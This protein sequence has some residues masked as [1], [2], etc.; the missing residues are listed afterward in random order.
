[1]IAYKPDENSKAFGNFFKTLHRIYRFWACNEVREFLQKFT[2]RKVF[3]TNCSNF[4]DGHIWTLD[5]WELPETAWFLDIPRFSSVYF[6]NSTFFRF[7]HQ[8]ANLDS[9]IP[10]TDC[11]FL[12]ISESDLY[13][14]IGMLIGQKWQ[15]WLK[16]RHISKF[17]L[18]LLQNYSFEFLYQVLNWRF[19]TTTWLLQWSISG[20]FPHIDLNSSIKISI[21]NLFLSKVV[22][23]QNQLLYVHF[24]I[25]LIPWRK[26][27]QPDCASCSNKSVFRK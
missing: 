2:R 3:P 19:H 8:G 14:G 27:P 25:Y 11:L 9:F 12:N 4:C 18:L 24:I 6:F 10:E 13:I 17:Q 5:A 15:K 7:C 1:M 20:F 21:G 26:I 22:F 23:S 16:F